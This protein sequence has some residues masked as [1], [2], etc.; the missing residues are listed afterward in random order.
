M[1]PSQ[2]IAAFSERRDRPEQR[3][4]HPGAGSDRGEPSS[5]AVGVRPQLV[6]EAGAD[7]H[8]REPDAGE[9]GEHERDR[10]EGRERGVGDERARE[11]PEGAGD[12]RADRGL[13]P[14]EELVEL[15]GESGLDVGHRQGEHEEEAGQHEAEP[16]QEAAELA[17]AQAAEVDAQLVGLRAG[18]DLVDGERL[19]E[20]LLVDP[21]LLVDALALDH[22]DL[23]GRA[24]PG[25]G[26]ELQEAQ[27]EPPERLVLGRRVWGA[28]HGPAHPT[29]RSSPDGPGPRASRRRRSWRAP[30]CRACGRSSSAARR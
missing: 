28:G 9:Q 4:R 17:A 23:R 7:E 27:E 12:E 6:G 8:E 1:R 5:P 21:A 26:A 30:S 16:G 25:E 24:A 13:E 18:E 10:R 19:L 2:K 20:G 22:R 29:D 11:A 15:L 14:V 3:P